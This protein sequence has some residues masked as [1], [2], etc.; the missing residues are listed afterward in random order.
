MIRLSVIVGIEGIIRSGRLFTPQNLRNERKYRDE[1]IMDKTKTFLKGKAP[2]A[3]EEPKGSKRRGK[4]AVSNEE[5]CEFFK[6]IQQSEYKVVD[7]L[8]H[9]SA[10][11]S[12]LELLMHSE[13]QRKL[14]MKI[15]SGAYVEQDISL[16]K[17]EG[18]VS[19]LTANN[20]LNFTEEEVP[21][22]GKGHNKG[23]HISV[24]YKDYVIACVLI[25]NGS[26]LNVMPKA[27]LDRLPCEGVHMRPSATVVRA[28][29]GSR[30]EVMG[31]IKLP[32][33]VGPCTFQIT[34]QVM[35]IFLA[36]S[37]FLGH[38]W[39][40]FASVATSTLHQKL[41]FV[42]DDKLIIVYGEE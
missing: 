25:D 35:D 13:T 41:K 39:I 11:I 29:E 33:Q 10:Q 20:Y 23:L 22:E 14:L 15:L 3:N 34:F 7:Q 27:T 17:F 12:L 6:F 1:V 40:H 31:E 18:I 30:R 21:A 38:P 9:M 24:T 16:D 5:A 28:F 42:I 26:S 4:R 37:C 19:H 2:H 36:Y 32:V 8:N